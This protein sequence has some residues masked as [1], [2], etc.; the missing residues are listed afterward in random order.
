MKILAKSAPV[1]FEIKD[2]ID[3]GC[4]GIE[5]QLLEDF[6]NE[7][8]PAKFY[9]D[10]IVEVNDTDVCVVHMPLVD[11]VDINL[12]LF[13]Y[14]VYEKA[15]LKAAELSNM[16]GCYYKHNVVMVIHNGLS[17]NQ[18]QH[19]PILFDYVEKLLEF[20]AT[21]YKNVEYAF[22]N[23]LPFV[24]DKNR[25][26]V[27][28]NGFA[29]DN[30]DLALYFNQKFGTNVFGTVIDTCHFM[31][32]NK[33]IKSVFEANYSDACKLFNLK[34][35]FLR[36]QNLVKVFHL[37]NV[38]SLGFNKGQHG[39]GFKENVED[40]EFLDKFFNLYYQY[41]SDAYVTLE[42]YENDYSDSQIYL[43]TKKLVERYKK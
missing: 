37:A 23:I 20:T 6:L 3:K 33:I 4:D 19:M 40:M 36:N 10:K 16:L 22:E 27:T 29:Y 5:I 42:V 35:F 8:I 12:E 38:I 7:D 39:C 25:F 14:P 1:D 28:R 41:T 24:L 31:V 2:K 26:P 15:F 32:S 21:N 17:L 34:E 11:G 30:V 18:F 13:N 9:F 43:S